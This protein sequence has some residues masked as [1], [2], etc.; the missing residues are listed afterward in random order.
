MKIL[1]L[2]RYNQPR[3]LAQMDMY[4]AMESDYAITYATDETI[5]TEI[6]K[7]YDILWIGIYHSVI[8]IDWYKLFELNKKPVIIDQAD[9]E[10]FIIRGTIFDDI[11]NKTVLSRYLPNEELQKRYNVKLLPWYVNP[12]RFYPN[13]KTYDVAFICSI[14]GSRLGM[15][16]VLLKEYI[17]K[18][19]NYMRLSYITG[20]LFG[21]AYFNVISSAKFFYIDGSR[22]CLTVKY[23][24]A[25]LMGC[26]IIGQKPIYPE[27]EIKVFD[28]LFVAI[29]GYGKYVT[30]NR[31]YVMDTFANK[32]YFLNNV[33]GII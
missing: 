21:D 10:E 2:D 4:K 17:E 9:N 1:I 16:R 19:A 20:E 33:K 7:Q 3:D 23:I 12:E 8:K 25:T 18:T 27:N 13:Q 6:E 26:E 22:L 5:F 31:E 11:P 32:Q 15:N 14:Y 30:E 29:N 24:E 28:N